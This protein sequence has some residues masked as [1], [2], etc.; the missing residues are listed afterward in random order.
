MALIVTGV[1]AVEVKLRPGSG[2]VDG[3]V[4]AGG[5]PWAGGVILRVRPGVSADE[6]QAIGHTALDLGLQAVVM[7]GAVVFIL[8]DAEA[9]IGG[10][11][12]AA[13]KELI[14]GAELRRGVDDAVIEMVLLGS[15]PG[16]GQHRLLVELALHAERI[17]LQHGV[18]VG[19]GIGNDLHVGGVGFVDDEVGRRQGRGGIGVEVVGRSLDGEILPGKGDAVSL[20]AGIGGGAVEVGVIRELIADAAAV[21][22]VIDSVAAA[23][24]CLSVSENVI[25][26]T[27]PRPEV[28]P[29]GID[30]AAGVLADRGDAQLA[31]SNVEVGLPVVFLIGPGENVIAQAEIQGQP[32]R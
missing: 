32:G 2:G 31:G 23:Q 24:R 4:A 15:H 28:T 20:I 14:A 6:L 25:G 18:F 9:A 22:E 3:T 27:N 29:V 26:K 1:T 19:L 13:V 5:R 30:Q 12:R 17:L 8:D 7:A 16:H 10:D 11:T 21:E